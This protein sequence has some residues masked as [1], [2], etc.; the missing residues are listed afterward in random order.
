[1][2]VGRIEK[3]EEPLGNGV[4]AWNSMVYNLTQTEILP[5]TLRK[6]RHHVQQVKMMYRWYERE[7]CPL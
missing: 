3:G 7:E 1:V 5:E 4:R 2:V 6:S